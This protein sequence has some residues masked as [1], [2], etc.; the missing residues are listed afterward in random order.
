M[1]QENAEVVRREYEGFNR[2][3]G[4]NAEIYDQAFEFHDLEGAPH[5]IRRGFDE[6]CNW[7]REIHEAFGDFI[8]EP[9][10]LLDYGE[11]VVA[12]I[13]VRGRGGGS[14]VELQQIQPPLFVVWTFCDGKI[15]RGELFR[16]RTE[17]LAALSR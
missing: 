4:L 10:E 2:T 11:Q 15:V 12:V 3:G 14:G 5:P 8:L 6:W 7:A 9:Q 16:T 17:A 1:T 13:L